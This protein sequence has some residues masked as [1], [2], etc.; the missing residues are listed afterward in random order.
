MKNRSKLL[1]KAIL[2]GLIILLVA[3]CGPSEAPSTTISSMSPT[4]IPPPSIYQSEPNFS[5]LYP[6]GWYYEESPEC[7]ISI[8]SREHIQPMQNSY[9][10]GE[11]VIEIINVLDTPSSGFGDSFK[12]L[13]AYTDDIGIKMPDQEPAHMVNL[14]GRDFM[15]GGYSDKYISTAWRGNRAP[16]F[17]AVYLTDQNTIIVDMYA[18]RNDEVQLRRVFEEVLVSIEDKP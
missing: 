14:N 6:E 18:A 13:E 17:I 3:G 11:I 1:L 10:D 5:L 4:P 15:I 16:L 12:A 7:C 8:A 9:N 2:L